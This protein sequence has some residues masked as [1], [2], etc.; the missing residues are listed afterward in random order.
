MPRVTLNSAEIRMLDRQDPATSTHGGWQS[1]LVKLQRQLNR[2]TGE[3]IL[4]S[5]D[6]ERIRRYAFEYGNGGWE[7]RLTGVFGRTLGPNLDADI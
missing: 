7:S 3:I 2:S 5:N 1:L 6:R 4:Y